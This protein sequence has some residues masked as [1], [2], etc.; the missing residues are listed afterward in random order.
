MQLA[1]LSKK[2]SRD[3]DF[4]IRMGG[5]EFMIVM[6]DIDKDTAFSRAEDFCRAVEAYE[7]QGDK[8]SHHITI[9]IGVAAYPEDDRDAQ[10]V[11]RLSDEAL[12][13]AKAA[14]KNRVSR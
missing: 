14:G 9:S 1:Q 3:D 13:R 10:M 8:G 7:F 6:V 5:E 12:Y 2:T 11:I 4:I